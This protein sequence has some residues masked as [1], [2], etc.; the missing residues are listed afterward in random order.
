MGRL[1]LGVWWFL[2]VKAF[3]SWCR[4]MDL[5][6]SSMFWPNLHRIRRCLMLYFMLLRVLRVR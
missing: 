4:A 5:W 2:Y 1:M 6:G 3:L